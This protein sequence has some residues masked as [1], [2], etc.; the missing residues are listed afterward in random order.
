MKIARRR[1]AIFRRISREFPTRYSQ[2]VSTSSVL[3]MFHFTAFVL[4]VLHVF[5]DIVTGS[6]PACE[7]SFETC[8][9][10]PAL[11]TAVDP[12]GS[13]PRPLISPAL[14]GLG[15]SA[16]WSVDRP[17]L[18]L[19]PTR[20][21]LWNYRYARTPPRAAARITASRIF[22]CVIKSDACP[23]VSGNACGMRR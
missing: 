18:F 9:P 15:V 20:C 12:R 22:A 4:G 10:D 1:Y 8:S 23:M 2:C 11:P 19:P 17:T 3:E 6:L 13:D 21:L 5:S 16:V 14:S 7:I